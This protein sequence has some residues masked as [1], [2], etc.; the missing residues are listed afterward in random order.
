LV[1]VWIEREP[2]ASTRRARF[3]VRCLAQRLRTGPLYY[4]PPAD[5]SSEMAV[6]HFKVISYQLLIPG[7]L[8]VTPSRR[9]SET[10]RR[11]DAQTRRRRGKVEA[12]SPAR[13]CRAGQSSLWKARERTCTF[14]AASPAVSVAIRVCRPCPT[15]QRP[16]LLDARLFILV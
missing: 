13:L 4:F 11:L 7:P 6:C 15:R 12:A 9:Y 3:S 1:F 10:A 8:S 16:T 14:Y 5:P 2:V